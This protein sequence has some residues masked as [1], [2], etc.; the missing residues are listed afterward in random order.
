M[1][2]FMVPGEYRRDRFNTGPFKSQIA[3]L[4]NDFSHRPVIAVTRPVVLIFM[5]TNKWLNRHINLLTAFPLPFAD[6]NIGA[7]PT[8]SSF[9][10]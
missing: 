5:W 10:T 3:K 8:T 7:A 2:H 4:N 6:K 9:L 1:R